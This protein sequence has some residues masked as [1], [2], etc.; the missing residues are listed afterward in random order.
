MALADAASDAAFLRRMQ[1]RLLR[2]DCYLI[3]VANEDPDDLVLAASTVTASSHQPGGEPELIR[4]GQTRAIHGRPGGRVAHNLWEDVLRDA[5]AAT[6]PATAKDAA[7]GSPPAR[8]ESAASAAS[9][10]VVTCAPPNRARP[11]LHRWMSDPAAGLPAWIEVRWADPVVIGEV[12]L[13][14]DTGQH[15]HLTLSQADGYTNKMQWGRPQAETVSDYAIDVEANGVWSEIVRER[16][17]YQRRR[18]HAL[19]AGRTVTAL[20]VRVDATH[21]LHHARILEVRAYR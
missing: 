18:V 6:E 16:G 4:S 10:P 15:R 7:A 11:G 1:Q 8:I 21:G 2:D 17:N 12:Q 14:F 3:G 13:I 19:A 20:R 9:A 5:T